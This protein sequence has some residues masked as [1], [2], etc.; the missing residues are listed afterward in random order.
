MLIA[1]RCLAAA[2]HCCNH[3]SVFSFWHCAA[4]E[5]LGGHRELGGDGAR[6]ADLS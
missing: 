3:L 4:S 6:T 5:G 1:Q 2:E